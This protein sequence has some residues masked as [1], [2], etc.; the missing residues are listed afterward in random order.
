MPPSSDPETKS[1]LSRVL[2]TREN[3]PP[4]AWAR[5]QRAV[6][7]NILFA[8]AIALLLYTAWHVRDVLEII[9]VSALFAVVLMPVMRGIMKL[10]IGKWSPGR[11]SAIFILFLA[12]AG[13]ASLFFF[14][15][16]PPVIR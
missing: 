4:S 16:L 3:K 8:F 14:V 7:G 1:L 6:R 13:A 15:A 2:L 9:Y 11:G 5:R 10:Q 12:V